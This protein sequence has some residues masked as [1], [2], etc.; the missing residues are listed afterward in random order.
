MEAR[1]MDHTKNILKQLKPIPMNRINVKKFGL[2]FGFTG[3]LLYAGCMTLMMTV[4]HDGTITFFNSLLHGLDVSTVVRMEVPL[5]EAA[6][7]IV[8]TFILG[9]LIGACIAAVY[10]TGIREIQP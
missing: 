2:A 5:W 10:N 1:D 6:I 8:E 4:G 3:A 9:W 7:G